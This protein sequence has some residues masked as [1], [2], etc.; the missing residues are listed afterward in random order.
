MLERCSLCPRQCHTK[1]AHG[2]C[3]AGEQIRVARA[4]PHMWEE[5]CLSGT[6][7]A[8]TVF[9][10]HCTLGC[11]YCQNR[12]ISGRQPS[13]APMTV[14][15]L[16]QVFL[17]LQGQGVHN[18]E[19][20]TPDHYVPQI[21]EAL[22]QAKTQGLVLPIVYNGSGYHSIEM[23]QRL[24]GWVDV[25]LPDFKYYSSY[26]AARYS[27]AA[28]YFEVASVAINEMV[29]QTGKP[30]FDETGMLVRGVL[31][32]HLMLP[33]LAGDTA[34]ILRHLAQ[35]YGDAVLVSLLRQYTPPQT[36][37]MDFPELMRIITDAEYQE[38]MIMLEEL[39]LVG[40]G[41]QGEAV[42]ESFIP[43][44]DGEIPR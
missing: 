39:G 1:Q 33:T 25:Y 19:L 32:R 8:G 22:Q 14:Q 21:I 17:R 38:A 4:A 37:L 26:Y 2:F 24:E 35:H 31:V 10:S 13:G 36:P 44:W 7:G 12:A 15:Q 20:V 30:Q 41:Q 42:G 28:D 9:F 34:Q 27:H 5:P 23:L 18:I 11:V 16:A 3:N 40:Y 43:S 29:R 6:Q